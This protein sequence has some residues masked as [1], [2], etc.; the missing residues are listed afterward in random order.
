MLCLILMFIK[1]IDNMKLEGIL[2]AFRDII[3][4]QTDLSWLKKWSNVTTCKYS[5]RNQLP[6]FKMEDV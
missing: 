1:F 2:N 5:S 4:I 6:E 3:R